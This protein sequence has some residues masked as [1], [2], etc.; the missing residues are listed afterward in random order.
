M[1]REVKTDLEN[2]LSHISC[3]EDYGYADSTLFSD[4]ASIIGTLSTEEIDWYARS[5]ADQPGYGEEDY[6]SIVETL[7]AFKNDYLWS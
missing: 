7:T 6:E 4:F 5:V 2:I 1:N 3:A